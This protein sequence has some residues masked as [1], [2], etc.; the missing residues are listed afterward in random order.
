MPPTS[1]GFEANFF[2]MKGFLGR[3]L[4]IAGRA[5]RRR[6]PNCGAPGIFAG[7]F[8]TLPSCPKCGLALERKEE[9]YR[10]GAYMFNMAMAEAVFAVG[11]VL[12]LVLTW[13]TPP[14]RWLTWV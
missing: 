9:G 4:K 3:A 14:W 7:W 11:F 1:A 10:V 2:R 13:P 12:V 6:C 8:R 5:V